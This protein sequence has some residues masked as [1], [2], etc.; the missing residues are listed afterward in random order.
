MSKPL[1]KLVECEDCGA[2]IPPARVKLTRSSLCVDCQEM[3]ER[4]GLAP[5]FRMEVIGSGD[6]EN[7]ETG[8]TLMTKLPPRK[9]IP[10]D[11]A[12]E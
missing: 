11:D 7:Y 8:K 6:V 9:L 4:Q 12:A 3:L 1:S 5:R 10:Q 2:E